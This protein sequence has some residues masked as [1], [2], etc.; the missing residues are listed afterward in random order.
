VVAGETGFVVVLLN[1]GDGTFRTAPT[2]RITTSTGGNST[3]GPV[4][5]GDFLGNGKQDIAVAFTDDSGGSNQVQV[6]LGN[7]DGSFQAG[8]VLTLPGGS[9]GQEIQS[10][11]VADLNGD[12]KQ[13]LVVASSLTFGTHTGQLTVFLSN[14]DGTFAAPESFTV[15]TA[16]NDVAVADLR[17]NGKLDL[18]TTVPATGGQTAVEVLFGNGD[19]T[20]GAPVTVFTGAGGKL[21]VGNFLGHGRQDIVTFT[22]N[23]TVN[24]L[25]NNGDGTFSS[26]IT[27]QTGVGLGAA[28]VDDFFRDGHLSLAFTTTTIPTSPFASGTPTG[29]MVLRGNGDGTFQNGGAFLGGFGTNSLAVGDFAGHGKI[30]LATGDRGAVFP[31]FGTVSVLLNQSGTTAA[32]PTVAS[33]VA[34]AG[35]Q[36]GAPVSSVSITFSSTV[37]LSDGAVEVQRADGSDIGISISTSVVGGKSVAVITFSGPDIVNGALPD[38]TY[39]LILHGNLVHDGQGQ[40]LGQAFS[41]DR[42]AEFATSDGGT[43]LVNDFHP[44]A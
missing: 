37:S 36:P 39:T 22:S 34:N 19:G 32:A 9:F 33:A 15:G 43:D 3:A 31:G 23:G 35:A 18:I 44:V 5:V 24:V 8:P 41:G 42:A 21:A 6:Y 14:G 16:A 30:D 38:G 25:A 26:P 12:G 2:L 28:V 17:G 20:F 11:A 27:T 7:G 10:L 13:D 40:V 1:N 29:V 4:A